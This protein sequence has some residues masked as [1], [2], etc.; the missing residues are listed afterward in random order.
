MV[1][2]PVLYVLGVLNTWMTRYVEFQ[3]DEFSIEMGYGPYL[4]KGLI[5][6]F[7]NNSGNLNPDSVYAMLKYDHPALIE[8]LEAIE[9]HMEKVTI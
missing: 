6:L 8:R 9:K 1:I 4:H 5:S 3:A 2:E 7:I